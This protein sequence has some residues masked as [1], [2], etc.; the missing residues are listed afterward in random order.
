[1]PA[2]IHLIT[3]DLEKMDNKEAMRNSDDFD[4]C[5]VDVRDGQTSAVN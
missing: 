4:A 2:S 3:L 5:V 1:M